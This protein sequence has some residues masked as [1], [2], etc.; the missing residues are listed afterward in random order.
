MNVIC[1]AGF[2]GAGKTSLI[3]RL[4]VLLKA[5]GLRVS[6]V[7]HTH[8]KFD[9]DKPGKDTW[10]HREA[11]ALEV[12][13]ASNRRFVLMHEYEQEHEPDIHL[14]LK[15]LNPAVDWVLVEGFKRSNLPKMEVWRASTKKPLIAPEDERVLA[16]ATDSPEQLPAGLAARMLDLNAP[17]HILQWMLEHAAFFAYE[18]GQR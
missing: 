5:Q 15:Q 18:H 4:I 3:E 13:A 7:K 6:V 9:L 14:L 10:R 8:H 1:F 17:G 2:S 16:I 12:L 11:G